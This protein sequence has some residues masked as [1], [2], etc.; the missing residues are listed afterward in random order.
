MKNTKQLILSAVSTALVALGSAAHAQQSFDLPESASKPSPD[1]MSPPSDAPGAP[2]VSLPA[3]QVV[4]RS[5]SGAYYSQEATG[6]KSDLPL[7]ELP[8]AVRVMSRQTLDD[9]GAVRVDDVLD[10]V[11]G[12]SRQNNFGGLWDNVAI[13][14][15]AGDIN[16]GMP[17]LRNGFSANRG[18]NAPR[19]TA[20]IERIEFLKGPAAALYGASEPG[21]TLNVVTK[22]PSRKAAHAFELYAGSDDFYRTAL[23]ST[24]PLGESVAY[25]LNVAVEDRGSFR[26][27]VDTHRTLFAPA[28]TW[29]LGS[30]TVLEYNGELLRHRT[31]LDRG[32]VAVNEQLGII[33]R[34]RFL[35]EPA[36]GD[37]EVEN[38]T[39][40]FILEHALNLEWSARMGLSY[41]QGSVEGFSTEPQ[42]SVRPDG[43]TL[44]RQ[45]RFRDYTSEDLTLQGEVIG[46]FQTGEIGHELVVGAETYRMDF[47]QRM[48]R[49]NPSGGAPYAI[50]IFNP[51]Y[52]QTQPVPLPNTDTS[53]DQKNLALYVQDTLSLGGK[54]RLMGGLRFDRYEQTLFNRLTN[55]R[56][57]QSPTAAS[58]RAGVSY[59]A[60]DNWTF[61]ANAGKSFRPNNGTSAAGIS[62]DPE[63][64]RALEVGSKWENSARTLGATLALYD[65]RKKNVLTSDPA[66]PGFSI[67]AGEVGSRGF[68]LDVSGQLSPHWRINASLAYVDATVKRDNQLQVGSRL[69][70]IPRVNGSVLVMY[71]NALSGGGRYGIGGGVTH[72]SS[73]PGD[74]ADPTFELPSYTLAKLTAY[75]RLNPKLRVSLDIDNLFDKTYYTSSYQQTWITPGSPRTVMLG[76]QL[77]F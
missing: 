14:G 58:P 39:H 1:A 50:D 56:T 64:G 62:F 51:V 23:D 72:S 5:E 35:G 48:L 57:E 21:G 13:R 75:W 25:R 8:Q 69:L 38:Q 46:R 22:K 17:L 53:E 77:A 31:P 41:K 76:M 54:W 10:Y 6:T 16:N 9:L 2:E 20:N 61:F 43:R 15:L 18:F 19:D 12:V 28:L 73:R 29:R 26:D 44:W 40:Q 47:D 33:P 49:A 71:E 42:S 70:N 36:D 11:G 60:N 34:E 52:G 30:S 59:L 67:A 3:V 7:R 74:A 68:D 32:V 4:G 66:N 24:G 65:I 45:R 63:S 27:F 55:R 37:V